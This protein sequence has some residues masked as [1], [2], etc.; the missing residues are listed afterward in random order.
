MRKSSAPILLIVILVVGYARFGAIG[1]VLAILGLGAAYF[2]SVRLHPRTRHWKCNGMG[3][4][5]SAL[6]PWT[7]RRCGGCQGGRVI[8]LGAG[9]IGAP[10]IRSEYARGRAARKKAQRERTWR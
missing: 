8:R 3:E 4:H 9:Q 6:F 7:H 1:L 2:G 5:R 10:H